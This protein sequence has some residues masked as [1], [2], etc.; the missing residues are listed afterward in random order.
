MYSKI[1]QIIDPLF[2]N[3]LTDSE[4]VLQTINAIPL[5]VYPSTPVRPVCTQNPDNN[6]WTL[7]KVVLPAVEADAEGY[8]PSVFKRL[9][10]GVPGMKTACY[11]NWGNLVNPLNRKYLDE[12]SVLKDDGCLVNYRKAFQFAVR[13]RND[14]TMIFLYSVHTDHTGHQHGSFVIFF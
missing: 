4:T 3:S 8:H 1:S 7:K 9:K 2:D 5:R 10:D 12:V 11:Y 6:N 13:N 14:P